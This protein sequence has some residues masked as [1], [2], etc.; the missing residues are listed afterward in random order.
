MPELGTYGSVPGRE[1]TRV[2]TAN[3]GD[4]ELVRKLL[5]IFGEAFRT[6]TRTQVHSPAPRISKTCLAAITSLRWQRLQDD[7]VIGGLAAYE[8][9]KFERERSEIYSTT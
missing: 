7:A 6:R 1:V 9:S 2:P 5:A 4:V 3:S 8:L